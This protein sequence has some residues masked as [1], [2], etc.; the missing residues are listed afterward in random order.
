MSKYLVTLGDSVHW[1]QGLRPANKIHTRVGAVLRK[2]RPD[3]VDHLLAHSGATIGVDA[4]VAPERVHG[5]V[6][7]AY[8]TLFQQLDGFAGDPDEVLVALVNGGINDVDLRRILSI[9]TSLDHL[10]DLTNKHCHLD[11][12]ALLARVV[13]R[14]PQATILVT[15]YYPI[16]SYES[17][18]FGI[19]LLLA[20][21]G[22]SVSAEV[23][24][25]TAGRNAIVERALHFWR[26]SRAALQRAVDDAASARVL[27]VDPGFT[28]ANAAF[29]PA[30]LLFGL[31]NDGLLSPEDEVIAERRGGCNAAIP[32]FDAGRR[33][34]CYRASAGHPNA[35][36]ARRYAEAIVAALGLTP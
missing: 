23:A 14:F 7:I 5:E 35:R 32:P 36:G 27:F 34:Q 25:L 19:P 33:F 10:S 11:M 20:Q 22:L 8:P 28:E 2:A 17:A 4:S 1:G 9:L 31:R 21:E 24:E 16:L 29:A 3:L 26:E 6:P 18:P 15:G 12:R 13:P 30:S